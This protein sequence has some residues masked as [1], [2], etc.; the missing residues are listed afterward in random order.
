[1]FVSKVG[2]YRSEHFHAKFSR[3]WG[4]MTL[5][6]TTLSMMD[7]F[8]IL[9]INDTQ[10]YAIQHNSIELHYAECHFLCLC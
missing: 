7:L 4:K 10:L 5:S 2:T 8:S 9:G 3:G 1:M 6:I